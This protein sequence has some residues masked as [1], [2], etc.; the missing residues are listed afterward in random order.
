MSTKTLLT[1]TNR[2]LTTMKM[3]MEMEM[4]MVEMEMEMEMEM[5][6][7]IKMTIRFNMRFLL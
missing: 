2:P 6:T 3:E 4:E 5:G 7:G 1:R